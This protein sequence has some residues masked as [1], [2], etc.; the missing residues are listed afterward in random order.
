MQF[1]VT[2]LHGGIMLT[3]PQGGSH[4][5][6]AVPLPD[7]PGM[8]LVISKGPQDGGAPTILAWVDGSAT[9]R[10]STKPLLVV[11]ADKARCFV[12]RDP[13]GGLPTLYLGDASF[14]VAM[15]HALAA[16]NLADIPVVDSDE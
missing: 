3:Q 14:R 13:F 1:A 7:Y 16:A 6:D 5:T 11:N 8:M 9:P 15:P 12:S 4:H 2:P 10:R